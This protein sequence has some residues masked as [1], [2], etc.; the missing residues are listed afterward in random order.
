MAK[1]ERK[2]QKQSGG[3]KRFYKKNRKTQKCKKTRK[4]VHHRKTNRRT[5]RRLRRRNTPAVAPLPLV[6]PMEEENAPE[7]PEMNAEP[8]IVS[9]DTEGFATPTNETQE[10]AEGTNVVNYGETPVENTP[11]ET[12]EGVNVVPNVPDTA[13]TTESTTSTESPN[14]A[15]ALDFG[16][17]TEPEEEETPPG[18]APGAAPAVGGKRKNRKGKSKKNRSNKK[19]SS[20][21]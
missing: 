9:P 8:S 2:T 7:T 12:P 21:R 4:Y 5:R 19:R 15:T 17:D 10:P 6:V 3:M 13:T 11:L 18:A 1:F 14:V 16:S 20:K